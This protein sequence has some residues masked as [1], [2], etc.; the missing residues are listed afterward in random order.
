MEELYVKALREHQLGNIDL[1]EKLYRD[2]IDENPNNHDVLH[3]LGILSA[4]RQDF[5]NAYYFLEKALVLDPKSHILHNSIGNV[6][7]NLGKNDKALEHYRFA[8]QL[9]PESVSAHNNL[10]NIFYHLGNDDNAI[11]HYKNAIKVMPD[12]PD[13]YYNIS[14]VYARNN[15]SLEA[16]NNLKVVLDLHPNHEKA[17]GSLGYL[18]QLDGDFDQAI[19]FYKKDLELNEDNVS[20]LHNLGVIFTNKGEYDL[21]KTYFKKV[22]K[23]QSHHVESLNNLGTIYI[24]Q[25]KFSDAL[26]YFATLSKLVEEFDVYYNL[27]VIYF[28]LAD[29]KEAKYFFSKS[30]EIFPEDFASNLNLGVVSLKLENY[31]DAEKYYFRAHELQPDNEE[32]L[33]LLKAI[34]QKGEH[35]KA[36]KG[37]LKNLFNRY[38]SSFDQ[39]L[40]MLG[41]Q[42]PD[43]IFI[44]AEKIFDFNSPDKILSVLDLGCGTGLSGAKFKGKV[45]QLVGVDISEKMLDIAASKGIY[46]DLKLGAI[47]EL[48]DEFSEIDLVMASDSLVYFGD[49]DSVFSKIYK[50]LKGGGV[51]AF[52]VELSRD[53]YPYVLQRSARFAHSF[54]YIEEVA[55]KNNFTVLRSEKIILRKHGDVVINGA[56]F[57][58]EKTLI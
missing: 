16:K 9:N 42:V 11:T 27:G 32:V 12:H 29:F 2:I 1:A 5:L 24:L 28:E 45:A 4:Q 20:S 37:Y 25:K 17:N 44:E 55:S 19:R 41:H 40:E 57:F 3:L 51:F 30:L 48:I 58:L 21:A 52:S 13:A 36:P 50:V 7:K 6:L 23:E 39:H 15:N 31:E 8:L 56:L 49:L 18:Y 34:Q 33:Y 54:K 14:L 43:L 53:I 26:K 46:T 22:L 10:G 35:D 38:A 47:E